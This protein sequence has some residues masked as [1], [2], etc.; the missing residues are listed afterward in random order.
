VSLLDRI[1]SWWGRDTVERAEDEARDHVTPLERDLDREEFEGRRADLAAQ[2][3]TGERGI[4][5]DRDNE[6]PRN[7]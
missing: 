1:R 6:P 4:N 3:Y 7:Y 2:E 5:F